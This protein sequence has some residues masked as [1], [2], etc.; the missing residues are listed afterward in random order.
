[1][2]M[3]KANRKTSAAL[4]WV[5]EKLENLSIPYQVVGGLAARV[6]GAKR[7]IADIDMYIPASCG[8]RL[9][10]EMQDYLTKPLKH[11]VEDVWDIEYFQIKFRGQKIEFG[12]SPGAKI[13]D[14]TSKKWVEQ[15]IDFSKSERMI[16]EGIEILVM[17]R[18]DLVAY[19]KLL[20]REVDRW[21]IEAILAT[22]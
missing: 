20:G 18:D 3:I 11:Y 13:F 5:V 4:E 6:F 10:S 12:L 22:G 19:K 16:F 17:P 9:A 2:N 1:M 14:T 7:P 21:D 8:A 15:T